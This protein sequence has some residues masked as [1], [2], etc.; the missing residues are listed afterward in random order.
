LWADAL[1]VTRVSRPA[2][3]DYGVSLAPAGRLD[4]GLPASQVVYTF[5]LTNQGVQ[6]DS[7]GLVV[8]GA[9]WLTEV[10]TGTGPL[11]PGA[12]QTVQAT[13]WVPGDASVGDWDRATLVATS[14]S[15]P[16]TQDAVALV[17]VSQGEGG[18]TPT[19]LLGKLAEDLNGPPL[20]PGDTLRYTLLVT[21]GTPVSVTGVLISDAIPAHTSYVMD[22]DEPE[23]DADADPLVWS[24]QVVPPGVSLYRFEVTVDADAA[25]QVITNSACLAQAGLP[26]TCTGP[27]EPPG[28]GEVVAPASAF[29]VY[30]PLVMRDY[31]P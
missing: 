14:Q 9:A 24:G 23:A 30:L 4:G 21:N 26:V 19:L 31:E 27:V 15:D 13:V 7:F 28:G 22:S 29:R 5:T 3:G 12:S 16:A 2:P 20:Y 8:E 18:V 10:A 11:A 25:G 1:L 17:T 6:T